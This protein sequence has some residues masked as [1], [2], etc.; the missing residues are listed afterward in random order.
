VIT[1]SDLALADGRTLHVY[2]SGGDDRLTV[3]WHHG[4]PNIGTP[5]LPLF[6]ESERLGVRWSP[7]TGR[8]TGGRRPTPA[9]TW[10][11]QPET[12][13]PSSTHSASIGS[14]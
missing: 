4:T 2:D 1:E 3:C 6:S 13:R 8:A 14:R 9:A 5:P 7:P 10:R 12:S 11:R